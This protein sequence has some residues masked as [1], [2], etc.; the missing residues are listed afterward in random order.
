M[1]ESYEFGSIK[2]NGKVYNKDLIIFPNRI[3]ENWWRKEGHRLHIEDIKEVIA[4]KPEVLIIGTGYYGY[5][6]V[7]KEVIE[8]INSLGITLIIEKTKKACKIFN[9][10]YKNKKTVAALHLTC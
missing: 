1:I 10:F 3:K 5:M 7:L 2:I 8:K 4:E 6:E 9:D